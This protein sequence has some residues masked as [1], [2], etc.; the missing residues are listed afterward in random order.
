MLAHALGAL[1]PEIPPAGPE[2]ERP[3]QGAQR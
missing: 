3:A 2:H 1:V